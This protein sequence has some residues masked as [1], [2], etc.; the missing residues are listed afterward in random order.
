MLFEFVQF[1]SCEKQNLLNY[2]AC[3]AKPILFLLVNTKM[4][5]HNQ[6]LEFPVDTHFIVFL[7]RVYTEMLRYIPK[8]HNS[9][10]YLKTIWSKGI[11]L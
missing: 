4:P 6:N 7:G 10:K 11:K 1:W 5:I 3:T 2:I 8:K 9:E